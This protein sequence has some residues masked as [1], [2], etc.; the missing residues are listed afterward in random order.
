MRVELVV[1]M[2]IAHRLLVDA[3]VDVQHEPARVSMGWSVSRSSLRDGKC[4][5]SFV[6]DDPQHPVLFR[7]HVV[8]SFVFDPEH[9]EQL[10]QAH[11]GEVRVARSER[12]QSTRSLYW[13]A[14]RPGKS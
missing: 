5:V 4:L 8:G 14:N 2:L 10:G 13:W 7:S 1:D 9:F 3:A 6:V 11:G 12:A